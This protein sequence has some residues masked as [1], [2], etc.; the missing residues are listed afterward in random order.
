MAKQRRVSVRSYD[1]KTNTKTGVN[2]FLIGLLRNYNEVLNMNNSSPYLH[3]YVT[4]FE[5]G[6]RTAKSQVINGILRRFNTLQARL[7][8]IANRA[9]A[10]AQK[11]CTALGFQSVNEMNQQYRQYLNNSTGVSFVQYLQAIRYY[12]HARVD[13]MLTSDKK[14]VKAQRL[15]AL[16]Q[17]LVNKL[18]NAGLDLQKHGYDTQD[19]AKLIKT[20]GVNQYQA[21]A[22][23]GRVAE[24]IVTEV[25]QRMIPD[26]IA[27]FVGDDLTRM[28][29]TQDIKIT[30]KDGTVVSF[31]LKIAS[32]VDKA[33]GQYSDY[34]SAKRGVASDNAR[35]YTLDS[36]VTPLNYG[37]D[38]VDLI[39]YIVYN[40]QILTG[41]SF[42]EPV[43]TYLRYIV[44]WEFILSGLF[45]SGFSEVMIENFP[46]F[47]ITQDR[48]ISMA[49]IIS[50]VASFPIE[51][52][53]TLASQNRSDYRFALT[54]GKGR[55]GQELLKE[56]MNIL[57][58][59]SG[60]G[61][62]MS[63]V[64]LKNNLNGGSALGSMYGSIRS[65]LS[66][67]VS[68]RIALENIAKLL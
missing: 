3:N 54:L 12:K 55:S 34:F 37:Q 60:Q 31:S 47:L 39:N 66:F 11:Q 5:V 33:T 38:T 56:K 52:M 18:K 6:Y 16:Q 4:Y 36:V 9:N 1:R 67:R 63:Y 57:Q 65:N 45:G 42:T 21:E 50:A 13:N 46:M 10:I 27:E 22:Y 23:I 20:I 41:T 40:N 2:K 58:Q 15:Q 43:M 24:P 61:A 35:L 51:K 44:G 19:Y 29:N 64:D 48:I 62:S 30:A 8:A 26:T 25:L 14:E 28:G 68:Y 49:D 59:Y 53:S 17:E 7:R 32:Q